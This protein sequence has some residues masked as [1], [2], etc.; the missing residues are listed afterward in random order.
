M[1]TV[2]FY[3]NSTSRLYEVPMVVTERRE[4]FNNVGCTECT[5]RSEGNPLT[6]IRIGLVCIRLCLTCRVE[7]LRKLETT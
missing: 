5:M 4:G 7:L 1:S 6:E 2:S 3:Q